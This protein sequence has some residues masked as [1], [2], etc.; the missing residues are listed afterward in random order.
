MASNGSVYSINDITEATSP[1][2]HHRNISLQI[3][4][5]GTGAQPDEEADFEI[6]VPVR[7]QEFTMREDYVPQIDSAVSEGAGFNNQQHNAAAVAS[8]NRNGSSE[9]ESVTTF[10]TKTS[11]S[12]QGTE[13]VSSRAL[14]QQNT[15]NFSNRM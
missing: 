6:E 5:G 2:L 12:N 1:R 15:N 8:G 11:S 10:N 3:C 4:Q 14:Q 9:D 7:L 13:I